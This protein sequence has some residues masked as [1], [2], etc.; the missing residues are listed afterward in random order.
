MLIEGLYDRGNLV[1][2][3]EG[4]EAVFRT[5][6]SYKPSISDDYYTV[7]DGESLHDIARAKLGSSYLWYILA[8]VNPSID[9]IFSL[10]PGSVLLIPNLTIITSNYAKLE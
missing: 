8:D 10:V 5:P 1:Y 3:S 7:K 4:D 6:I 2:F 9:D